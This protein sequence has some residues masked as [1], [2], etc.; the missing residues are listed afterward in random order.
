MLSHSLSG[1]VDLQV[2]GFG[3]INF[4]STTLTVEDVELAVAALAM[5][6]TIAFCPTLITSSLVTYRQVL[7][8]LAKAM[9]SPECAG[10]LLGIH[11][12]GPF[13]SPVEGAVGVHPAEHVQAP[14]LGMFDELYHLAEGR[15]SLLTL[16][17]ELPGALD[18][19]EH[20]VRLGVRVS[21]GHTMADDRAVRQ[22]VEA[23]ARFSTHLGNGCPNL[24]HRHHNPIW[25][26]LAS[27]DLS[28]M[29][30][31]DG[32]HLPPPVIAAFLAAKGVERIL[33]TSDAAPLA[34]CPPGEY[35]IFGTRVLLEPGGRLRSLE[36]DNLAGSASTMLECMNFLAG[37]DLL[38]EEDLW[39]VGRDNPLA[40][41]GMRPS[42]L[43]VRGQVRYAGGRFH[44][45][46]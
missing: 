38:S 9:R 4:S 20:A 41:L 25:P 19:I 7:P 1:F 14:S 40:A 27:P 5:R 31:T 26:Q 33:V 8:V 37:L 42:D 16:A 10:S 11:L 13:I 24:L 45:A 15:V 18:L 35:S 12:E 36:R 39:R 30:I 3:G 23:G 17:P 22:A 32:H 43:R 29:I 28:A 44:V 2:N 21:I 6:G 46:A 34:G